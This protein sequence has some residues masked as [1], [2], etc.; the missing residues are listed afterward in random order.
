M[1]SVLRFRAFRPLRCDRMP[2]DSCEALVKTPTSPD[3]RRTSPIALIRTFSIDPI[4]VTL[5]PGTLKL[6]GAF[7]DIPLGPRAL[8]AV[9]ELRLRAGESERCE[10][11]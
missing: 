5:L 4:S 3:S 7:L 8:A 6:V 11:T 1:V 2:R 9:G 10:L